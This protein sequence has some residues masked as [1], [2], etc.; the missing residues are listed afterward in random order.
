MSS[1]FRGFVRKEVLHLLRD[2]QSLMILLLMPLIQLL[3]FGFALRTEVDDIKLVIVD[4]APDQATLALRARLGASGLYKIVSV[5]PTTTGLSEYFERGRARQA[6]IFESG[7]AS[8][9]ERGEAGRVQLI[10]DATDPNSGSTM[11]AYATNVILRYEAELRTARGDGTN[12]GGPIRIVMQARMRF[13]PELESVNLFVPGLMAFVLTLVSALMTAISISREKEMG[14][15]EVLLV[16]PLRPWQIVV[17][18][19][20]PYVALGFANVLLLLTAARLVFG[21]PI[22]GQVAL[23]L[24]ECLLY[25]VTALSLGVLI[26]TRASSQ[27]TA[28]MAALAGTMLPT[29][30]L[31]GFIFPIDSM[32]AWLQLLTNVVP[33][34]WFVVVVRGIMITGAGLEQLWQE[35]LILGGMTVLLLALSARRLAIRLE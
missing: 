2:R 31:S 25:T 8:R 17:G 22:R 13:N 32:P 6:L 12:G 16:S 19:V 24:A 33:A 18:K 20:T 34:R 9:L 23:L 14:T 27:R 4:P 21:V 30:L 35:T 26:S 5:I 1:A 10:T 3:L 15:M 11:Q 29:M 7:F 28:M